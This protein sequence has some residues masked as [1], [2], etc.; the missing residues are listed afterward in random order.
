[1]PT[2]LD[3]VKEEISSTLAIDFDGV[4]HKNSKGYYDGSMYDDPVEGT[5]EAFKFLSTKFKLVIFTCKASDDRPL[6]D[7][8][9]GKTLIWE[10]LEKWQLKSYISEITE[11]KPRALFY[12]DD[13]GITFYSWKQT[14]DDI[15]RLAGDASKEVSR[16]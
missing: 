3:K 2:Y 9:D 5:E 13:K 8:K 16:F 7:G 11:K 15:E 1:M 14:L 6:V 12:I 4:I 10:W